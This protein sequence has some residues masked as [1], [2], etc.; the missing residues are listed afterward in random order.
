MPH[1]FSLSALTVL[2]LAPPDIVSCALEAGYDMVGLRLLAATPDET[3]YPMTG[4]TPMVRETKRRL[5]DAGMPVLDVE[6]LRLTPETDVKRDYEAFLETAAFLGAGNLLVAG[7]DPER[8][9]LIENFGELARMSAPLNLVPNIEFM[10]WTA[11]PDLKDAADLLRAVGEP[12]V[13]LLIDSIHF[14]RSLSRADEMATLPQHWFRYTQFCDAPAERPTTT[15]ELL[16]QGRV[17]RLLPGDGGLDLL[18]PFRYFPEDL[19]VSVEIPLDL[20]EPMAAPERA[21]RALAAT[22]KALVR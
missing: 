7:N 11:V 14:D 10:P 13:G 5:D 17:S 3:H 4:D 15:D 19:P 1:L 2:E 9:R 8:G 18:A 6:I 12:N 22:R 20:P 21:A 16:Y